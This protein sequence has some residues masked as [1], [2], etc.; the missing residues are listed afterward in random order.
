MTETSAPRA[1]SDSTRWLPMKLAPPVT[2]TLRPS[3][4]D[5][6]CAAASD[7]SE[8]PLAEPGSNNVCPPGQ[9]SAEGQHTIGTRERTAF[10]P[11]LPSPYRD[12]NW[13]GGIRS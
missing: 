8:V 11:P 5:F 4:S 6:P 10:L 13:E 12:S 3:H 9:V 1:M 2:A 7:E